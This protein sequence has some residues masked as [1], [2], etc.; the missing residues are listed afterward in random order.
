MKMNVEYTLGEERANVRPAVKFISLLFVPTF[1]LSLFLILESG[2]FSLVGLLGLLFYL[3]SLPFLFLY[4]PNKYVSINEGGIFRREGISVGGLVFWE[5]KKRAYWDD[6]GRVSGIFGILPPKW[7]HVNGEY[8]V[9]SNGVLEGSFRKEGT[10]QLPMSPFPWIMSGIADEAIDYV[11][12][13]VSSDKIRPEVI[14]YLKRRGLYDPE[15]H[16]EPEEC[17]GRR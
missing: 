12:E 6:I 10:V 5:R 15:R 11:C 14:Q 13:R 8:L 16:P 1:A 2:I 17:K 7:V 4:Y 9:E 3:I